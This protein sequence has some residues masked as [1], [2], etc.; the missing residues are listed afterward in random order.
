MKKGHLNEMGY[1]VGPKLSIPQ[2]IHWVNFFPLTYLWS[3]FIFYTP[4][5]HKKTK[6]FLMFSGCIYWPEMG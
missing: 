4:R 2:K 6:R 1:N 3:M 5:K